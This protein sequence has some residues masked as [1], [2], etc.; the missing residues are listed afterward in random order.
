MIDS[1]Y[2][3][4]EKGKPYTLYRYARD[5]DILDEDQR[6][7]MK[8]NVDNLAKWFAIQDENYLLEVF[9]KLPE[10]AKEKLKKVL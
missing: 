8:N 4:I 10:F 6:E 5:Q 7:T 2:N 3:T 1:H 9:S